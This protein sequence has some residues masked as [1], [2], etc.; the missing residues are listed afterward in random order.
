MERVASGVKTEVRL[1]LTH[2]AVVVVVVGNG[3]ERIA[4]V[5]LIQT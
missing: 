3:V 2:K 4:V 1:P 5:V